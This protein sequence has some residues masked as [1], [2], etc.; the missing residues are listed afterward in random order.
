MSDTRIRVKVRSCY[1]FSLTQEQQEKFT[2]GEG[3][4]MDFERGSTVEQLL[5][6]LPFVGGPDE[7]ND[8][9]LHVFVNGQVKGY[10]YALKPDDVVDLHIPCSGG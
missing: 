5:E 7:W 10:D 2:S 6:K 4:V 3:L 9:F 8:L 1:A